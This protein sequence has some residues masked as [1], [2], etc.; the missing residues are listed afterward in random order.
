MWRGAAAR[1]YLCGLEIRVPLRFR[2]TEEQEAIMVW[3]L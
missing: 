3:W 1:M 2:D